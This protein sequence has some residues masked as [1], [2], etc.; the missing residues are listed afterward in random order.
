MYAGPVGGASGYFSAALGLPCPPSWNP[1][2]FM[3]DCCVQGQVGSEQARARIG[4]D[5]AKRLD[6]LRAPPSLA[7]S[8]ERAEPE[9]LDEGVRQRYVK[10]WSYQLRVLLLRE[11]AIRRGSLWDWNQL[12]LH[13]GIAVLGGVMWYG[14]GYEEADIFARFTATFAVLIQWVFFPFLDGLFVFAAAE[15]TLRKELRV[16]AYRLSSWFVAKTSAG[17]L[18]YAVW[19]LMH[20]TI[21]YW[22]ASVNPLGSGGPFVATLGLVY[23]TIVMFQSFSLGLGAALSP[24]RVMT[25]ALLAMTAMVRC[26]ATAAVAA[27]GLPTP[28]GRS[29]STAARA[30]RCPPNPPFPPLP[31]PLPQFLFTGVF[32]PLEQTPLP[33]IGTINPLLYCLQAAAAVSIGWG[34]PYACNDGVTR[35]TAYPDVCTGQPGDQISPQRALSDAGVWA[36]LELSVG[37]MLGFTALAR[38]LAF[39]AL[40]SRMR[41]ASAPPGPVGALLAR[42]RAGA[43]PAH[44]LRKAGGIGAVKQATPEHVYPSPATDERV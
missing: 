42:L 25:F 17:L 10:P 15:V 35:G 33:W 1:A 2:D 44:K 27:A 26:K 21:L 9:A 4:R 23:L 5:A 39:R 32:I 22:M 30:R 20:V 24:G 12:Y 43:T 6:A 11:W 37:V 36:S 8:A 41:D 7:G 28:R 31:P 14:T 38:F 13:A 29:R 19:P 34:A 18:P 40:R 16:G 3:M